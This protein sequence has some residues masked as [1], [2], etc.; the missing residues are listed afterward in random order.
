MKTNTLFS[1]ILALALLAP[2]ASAWAAEL[3]QKGDYLLTASNT[4][5]DA[6]EKT[7]QAEITFKNQQIDMPFTVSVDYYDDNGELVYFTSDY[8]NNVGFQG[9]RTLTMTTSGFSERKVTDFVFRYAY[10]GSKNYEIS[11]SAG[12]TT[13]KW[14][15]SNGIGFQEIYEGGLSFQGESLTL[16]ITC[17]DGPDS[18][19]FGFS[20]IKFYYDKADVVLRD[21]K[22][23]IPDA[24]L[25]NLSWNDKLTLEGECVAAGLTNDDV[26]I[27]VSP[28]FET[29]TAPDN[30]T[31]EELT[32]LAALDAYY[33]GDRCTG[34]VNAN[35]NLELSVPCSGAYKVTLS[36]AE[37]LKGYTKSTVSKV[38]YIAPDMS[39]I[40]LNGVQ[41]ENDI[42][43][44]KEADRGPHW[45]N[46]KLTT[47]FINGQ[48]YYKKSDTTQMKVAGSA[49][50]VRPE[51]FTLYDENTGIDM[52]SGNELQLFA[53][54]NGTRS[55]VRTI[56]YSSDNILT[57]VETI[58]A[59]TTGQV[60]Y[61]T[62]DGR[63]AQEPLAP[64]LY[65]RRTPTGTEKII[66]PSR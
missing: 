34:K 13:K 20:D 15:I 25:L 12:D 3:P 35:R 23:F 21:P 47:G 24:E 17:L 58:T 59:D 44:V 30:L 53:E 62:I 32:A 60:E 11:L 28:E 27:S 5:W 4:Y 41:L 65:L 43:D 55:E 29:E 2:G 33:D 61:Y 16:I 56:S 7:N 26:V 45:K 14:T 51:G 40:A 50:E 57:G 38:L 36:T 39:T 9:L 19:L 54:K 18:E 66:I 46:A 52:S 37:G 63:R 49:P 1:T 42:L 64:G 6:L 10:T 48:I 22:L 31:D 8:T